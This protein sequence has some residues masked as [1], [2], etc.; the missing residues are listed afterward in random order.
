MRCPSWMPGGDVDLEL[1]A[2]R[3]VRPAP[4]QVV[5]RVLDDHAAARGTAGRRAC[6]RTRRTRCARPAAAG[7]CRRSAGSVGVVRAGLDAVAAARART[8]TATSN[9]TCDRRRRAPPRRARS[10]SRRRRRRRARRGRRAPPPKR[11]SPKNA[12]KRSPRL[13]RSKLRRLEAA[14]AQAGVPVAV[15]ERA[16]LGV[17]QHLV[18]LG[19]LA[20]ARLGVGLRRHVGMQLAREPA[21]RLLDRRL[22]GVARDAEQL[23]VVAVGGRHQS[24]A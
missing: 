23:V 10:R 3:R 21:E 12:E 15:V 24:S 20:E 14:R 16:R 19:H 22:V 13:P 18:R 4:S 7:R 17:R 6:A 5:A 11:S 9:G 1:A 2:P 8:A